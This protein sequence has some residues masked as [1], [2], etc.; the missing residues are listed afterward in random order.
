[1]EEVVVDDREIVAMVHGIDQLLA[2]ADQGGGASGCQV[3]TPEEFEPPRLGRVMELGCGGVG[4]RVEPG[5]GGGTERA[6]IGAE[7]AGQGL[8][9]CNARTSGQLGIAREDFAASATPEASPRPDSRSSQSCTRLAERCSATSRRSRVRSI[10]AR[11]RSAM[12]CSMSPKKEVVTSAR[13]S[14]LV[15]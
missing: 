11:P 8:E 13:I 6:P 4:G 3:E 9:E 5:R 14:C 7:P 15:G 2:H 12:D 1:M 10:S